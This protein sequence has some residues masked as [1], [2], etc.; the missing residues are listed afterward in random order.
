MDRHGSCRRRC[1]CCYQENGIKAVISFETFEFWNSGFVSFFVFR[2]SYFRFIRVMTVPFPRQY[3]DRA[4]SLLSFYRR[5]QPR[6][7]TAD[8]DN[9]G[10]FVPLSLSFFIGHIL[11]SSIFIRGP[12]RNHI[13]S[14]KRLNRRIIRIYIDMAKLALFIVNLFF[15]KKTSC[16]NRTI[17]IPLCYKYDWCDNRRYIHKSI[18][19]HFKTFN[20]IFCCYVRFLGQ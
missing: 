10:F 7:A 17:N 2:V 1:D 9:I 18:I 3:Y 4:A 15:G 8:N 19:D 13:S 5:R 6:K 20:N 11:F 16:D 14:D 12:V